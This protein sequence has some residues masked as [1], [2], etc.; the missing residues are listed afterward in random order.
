MGSDAHVVGNK[1]Q[2]LPHLSRLQRIRIC[3]KLFI[4]PDLRV[5]PIVVGYVI[6]VP[7]FFVRGE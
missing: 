4:A 1:I 3:A 6:A 2:D 7:A 5:D